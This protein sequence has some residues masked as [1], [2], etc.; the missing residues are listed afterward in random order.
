MKVRYNSAIV[1]TIW[2][3]L[4]Y[5]LHT[6]ALLDKQR[7]RLFG[8]ESVQ[9]SE[10][11]SLSSHSNTTNEWCKVLD[12]EKVMCAQGNEHLFS[13]KGCLYPKEK[14]SIYDNSAEP[15]SANTLL[16][17]EITQA[18]CDYNNNFFQLESEV[19]VARE[20]DTD[21]CVHGLLLGVEY[22]SLEFLQVAPRDGTNDDICS[23][24]IPSALYEIEIVIWYVWEWHYIEAFRHIDKDDQESTFMSAS[25]SYSSE[26]CS[27][28]EVQDMNRQQH[29]DVL[30]DDS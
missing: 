3:F 21:I 25:Y 2:N 8:V 30:R 14:I 22:E 20:N 23:L 1:S 28:N 10:I 19:H 9:P 24:D 12:V 5:V 18:L 27:N 26:G 16:D 29:I 7:R 15:G 11:L 6:Q 17:V 4:K 13:S